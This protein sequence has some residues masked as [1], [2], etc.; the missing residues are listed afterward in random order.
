MQT[1]PQTRGVGWF[2]S[3]ALVIAFVS[4]FFQLRKHSELYIDYVR[5][6]GDNFGV[7]SSTEV[8]ASSHNGTKETL[9][10]YQ[11]QPNLPST[12]LLS[13]DPLILHVH[14]FVTP[15]EREYLI[16]IA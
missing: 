13:T 2:T 8:R 12:V 1:K 14:N 9:E 3:L 4:A 6:F 11:C 10:S 7:T 16:N 15:F 5:R